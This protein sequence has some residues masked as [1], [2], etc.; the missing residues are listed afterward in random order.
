MKKAPT[1][2]EINKQKRWEDAYE[3]FFKAF[4]SENKTFDGSAVATFMRKQGLYEPINP[5]HWGAA[6]RRMVKRH[7]LLRIGRGIPSANSH[8]PTVSI[9]KVADAND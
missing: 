6:L 2:A 9:W 7:N 4:I 3:T 1:L 8:Q 5:G